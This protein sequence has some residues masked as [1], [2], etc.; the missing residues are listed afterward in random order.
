MEHEEICLY[1]AV[2]LQT[3]KDIVDARRPQPGTTAIR[4]GDR[5]MSWI[6]DDGHYPFSF[7][8]CCRTLGIEYRQARKT[9]QDLKQFPSTREFRDQ[10]EAC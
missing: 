3:I 10:R 2:M 9:I 6:D 1:R 4:R 8:D 7:R 5:A